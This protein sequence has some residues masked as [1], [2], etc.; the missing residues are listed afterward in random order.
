MLGH[1]RVHVLPVVTALALVAWEAVRNRLNDWIRTGGASASTR[2]TSA[3][4]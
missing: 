3:S 4:S 2:L 1:S